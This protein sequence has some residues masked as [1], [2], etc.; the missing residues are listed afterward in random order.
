M[1]ACLGDVLRW[2]Y[3]RGVF[4]KL[5]PMPRSH[6]LKAMTIFVLIIAE[7][8]SACASSPKRDARAFCDQYIA[9]A[10]QASAFGDPTSMNLATMQTNVV[11]LDEA[12]QQ[13]AKRAPKEVAPNVDA[14][15]VPMHTLRVSITKATTQAHAFDAWRTYRAATTNAAPKQHALNLWVSAHCGVSQV[16]PTTT[17]A[18][19]SSPPVTG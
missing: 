8:A 10:H 19:V 4:A 13:A 6:I 7:L 15:V 18:T 9:V 11:K 1:C 17:P 2:G 14:L 5:K 12:A 3:R 16:P